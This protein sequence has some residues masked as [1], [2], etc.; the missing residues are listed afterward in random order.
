MP[1]TSVQCPAEG[2][3]FETGAYAATVVA[4]ILNGHVADKHQQQQAQVAVP[5]APKVDRPSLT[6][7]LD[8]EQWNVFHQSWNIFVQANRIG[9]N[10][11]AVQLFS[12][13][14]NTLKA[15]LTSIHPDFLTKQP[16]ELLPLL[17]TICVTPVAISVKRNELLQMK[18]DGGETIRSFQ[19][20]IKLKA[21][22]CRFKV[23]C[24]HNHVN[25]EGNV[26]VDY[27]NEM[28]RHVILSGIYDEEIKRGI[29]GSTCIDIMD[30]N[31]LITLIES[32]ETARDATGDFSTSASSQYN[33]N[34]R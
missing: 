18:Q 33:Q 27:T 8:E 1:F 34:R 7:D 4:A 5:K 26:E 22:T 31:E 23:P 17:K 10:D 14:S 13:C 11:I 25:D 9:D 32:K 20:R 30:V 24:T 6:D 16:R 28:I 29:F 12:C 21:A 3:N 19:S 2:C 15:K